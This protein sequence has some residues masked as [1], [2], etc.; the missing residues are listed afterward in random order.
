MKNN[1]LKKWEISLLLALSITLCAGA[2]AQGRSA[3]ISG[4]LIRLHVVAASD[5]VYE[6]ELKLRVRDSV[7]AYLEPLLDVADDASE[8]RGIIEEALPGVRAAA[9]SAAEGR[10]VRV[11]LGRE[12]YP[13]REYESFTLPAGIYESL[14]VTLGEGE[15]RNWWCVVFPP[16]C[17]TAAGVENTLSAL[18]E[19]GDILAPGG[20]IEIRFRLVELWGELLALLGIR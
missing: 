10:G 5:A 4:S 19:A 7:L 18:G 14:R 2:W 6:Q 9:E 17:T 13:T 3:A 20:E 11:E 8:A 15:G 1:Y 16:L 12:A